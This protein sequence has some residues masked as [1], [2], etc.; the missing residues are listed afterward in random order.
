MNNQDEQR[1]LKARRAVIENCYHNL[2]PMQRQAVLTTQ[3]PLLL[4]AGAGAGLNIDFSSSPTIFGMAGAG[5]RM[6]LNASW[7][8]D[9]I[10]KLRTCKDEPPVWDEDG[11]YYVKKGDIRKNIAISSALELGIAISF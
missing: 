7:D 3:G 8:L 11:G 1:F 10:L 5:W 4:L 9:L 2:N 6:P